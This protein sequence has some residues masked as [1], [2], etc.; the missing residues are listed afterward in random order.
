MQLVVASLTFRPDAGDRPVEVLR[1][2]AAASREDE[3]C[4]SYEFLRSLDDPHTFRS[5]EAWTTLEAAAAHMQQAH[6][7]EAFGEL[8]EL[9]AAQPEVVVHDV[10]S[11]DPIG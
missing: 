1:R 2:L 7:H 4:E 3:G 8:A 5:I 6:V 10:Q 9:L 11:S